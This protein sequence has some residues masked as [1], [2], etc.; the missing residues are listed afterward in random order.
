MKSLTLLVPG[1]ASVV[2]EGGLRE[3]Y[4]F[5]ARDEL[6]VHGIAA[7]VA[8]LAGIEGP[9]PAGALAWLAATGERPVGPV[10]RIDPVHLAP[11]A[12]GLRLLPAGSVGLDDP[13]SATLAA[14][15]AHGHQI[16]VTRAGAWYW[17]MQQ[18]P[19]GVALEPLYD[20]AGLQV[21]AFL[22]AGGERMALR[23][24]LNEAQMILH[25]CPVNRRRLDAGQPTINS[26]WPWGDGSL[27]PRVDWPFTDAYADEPAVAGLAQLSGQARRAA[28]Q[29]YDELDDV[30]SA[31][32]WVDD[33]SA[34]T[35]RW[36]E[37][38]QH[39]IHRKAVDELVVLDGAG[40][41]WR[42]RRTLRWRIS[43]MLKS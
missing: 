3:L 40:T 19:A 26:I 16:E 15:L 25:D 14:F 27:P 8:W 41:R 22:P 24:W 43:R 4:R 12:D 1:L 9:L 21:G 33:L 2:A 36:L 38:A 39:A 18:P 35:A 29:S 34:V 10:T 31:F 23:R 6:P 17:L 11:D 20:V 32:A 37:P 30:H 42:L 13:D 7:T 5:A 28:A